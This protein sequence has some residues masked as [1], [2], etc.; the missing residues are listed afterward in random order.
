MRPAGRPGRRRV[1]LAIVA[2]LVLIPLSLF[3]LVAIP[4]S[5]WSPVPA[6]PAAAEVRGEALERFLS[7]EF[8]RVRPDDAPWAIRLREDDVNAW[9]ATRLPKWEANA[10]N[11]PPPAAEVRFRAGEVRLRIALAGFGVDPVLEAGVAPAVVDGPGG[12]ALALR[13]RSLSLGRLPLPRVG[14][15]LISASLR[16]AGLRAATPSAVSTV[17]EYRFTVDYGLS[18][19]RTVRLDA[20]AVEADGLVLEFRTLPR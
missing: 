2:I 17:T 15:S 10:G 4:P 20:I 5:G 9:I 8:S 7:A 11:P 12:A 13:L 18:D 19:G 6:D 16:A 1:R 3:L 14:A